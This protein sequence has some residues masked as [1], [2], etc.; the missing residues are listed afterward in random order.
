[1]EAEEIR[2]PEK[3]EERNPPREPAI[4]GVLGRLYN[5]HRGAKGK[6]DKEYTFHQ[7]NERRMANWARVVGWFTGA[8]VLTSAFANWVIYQQLQEMRSS[9]EDT[10]ALVKA[11][12]EAVEVARDTEQRQ[13]RAYVY[14]ETCRISS[15]GK[16]ALISC[17]LKNTGQTPA[18]KLAMTSFIALE[19]DQSVLDERQLPSK[20][21]FGYVG[22]D[23]I[24]TFKIEFD[25]PDKFFEYLQSGKITIRLRG[26]ISF[27]DVFQESHTAPFD[28][29]I[30]IFSGP[31][32]LLV[33]TEENK[34]SNK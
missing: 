6:K 29:R 27:A 7:S 1:M 18:Q 5:R 8:L 31:E 4:I 25:A 10:R 32:S 12:Q 19:A 15:F 20:S 23:S 3:D 14:I 9:G 28:F 34:P 2:Q 13:L 24:Y 26:E 21:Y 16:K 30:M 33:P 11:T 17:D 22:R